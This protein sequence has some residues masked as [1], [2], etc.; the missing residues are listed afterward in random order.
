MAPPPPSSRPSAR[1][2]FIKRRHKNPTPLGT[3]TF[4]GL[5]LLDV[6][7]Q[8]ALLSP[9][10]GLGHHLPSTLGITPIAGV[11]SLPF[12]TGGDLGASAVLVA[13]AAGSSLK[14]ILW[15]CYVSAEEFP[16]ASAAA[17][18]PYSTSVNSLNALLFLAAMTM[19]LRSAPAL[20]FLP[21]GGGGRRG[22]AALLL[23]LSAGVG[24]VLYPAGMTIETAAEWQRRAFKAPP[25]NIGKVR[26][27]A[28]GG[29]CMVACE[30]V[31][32]L[33]LGLWQ[34][35]DRSSRA[36][37]ALDECCTEKYGEQWARFERDI[38]YWIIPGIH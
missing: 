18:A 32:G 6:P 30:W 17:A 34:G 38:P 33:A 24:A 1:F 29:Y 14:Q 35:W 20:P 26:G 7:P 2:D 12:G 23:P 31:G 36:V 3:S 11:P 28:T 4:V 8:Y 15:A 5:R 10:V 37:T 16:P 21:F 25:A 13:M 19:S 22:R 27:R 9:S